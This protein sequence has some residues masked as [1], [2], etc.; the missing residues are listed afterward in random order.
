MADV[1]DTA[2]RHHRAAV[3]DQTPFAVLVTTGRVGQGVPRAGFATA[4]AVV[5]FAVDGSWTDVLAGRYQGAERLFLVCADFRRMSGPRASV[6]YPQLLLGAGALAQALRIA[7]DRPETGAWI[8][9][10]SL[11]PVTSAVRRRYPGMRHLLT[12]VAG[13][14]DGSPT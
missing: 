13:P 8:H 14:F 1:V 9:T 5:P 2:F 6:T 7:A 3:P 11:R 10:G 12:V 4:D